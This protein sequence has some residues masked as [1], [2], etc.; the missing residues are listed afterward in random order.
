MERCSVA[1]IIKEIQT[2]YWDFFLRFATV[3]KINNVQGLWGSEKMGM[4]IFS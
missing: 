2:K 3:K 4:I 1:L